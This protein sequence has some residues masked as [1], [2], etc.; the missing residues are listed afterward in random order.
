MN[1]VESST[2]VSGAGPARV[3]LYCR[4]DGG[5]LVL[6]RERRTVVLHPLWVRERSTSIGAIDRNNGQRLTEPLDHAAELAVVDAAVVESCSPYVDVTFSDR[7]R[8][9]LTE[10]DIADAFGDDDADAPPR[11]T[12]W[13]GVDID[14]PVIDYAA[15]TNLAS[16]D[17]VMATTLDSFFRLGFFLLRG[18]PAMPDALYEIASHFGRISAT[19]FGDLFDVRSDPVPIDLAYT[20]VAL[21]AHTD[22][23]YRRPVPGIQL[24]HTI[25]NDAPGGSSTVVDGLAAVQALSVAD[26]EA[27][28]VLSTLPIEFRYDIG[29]DVKIARAPLIELHPDGSLRELRYSPR[30]DF[31]PAADP[32]VLDIYYRGRRWLAAQLNSPSRQ[33]NIRMEAGDALVVD[34]HRVLHGRTSFDPT[35]GHRHLQGCYIDHD[36]P[37]T[38]WRLARRRQH[39]RQTGHQ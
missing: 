39:A 35:R 31:A 6:E 27:F 28:E 1:V 9:Q 25:A 29:T 5:R 26:P 14:A 22:Q 38:K 19:N 24:L 3:D 21:T 4:V 30:L 15:L 37:E 34:N 33:I 18:T 10:R 13:S 8:M 20:P 36:G 7:H 32:A 17:A 2:A 16:T 23:P 11:P 12:P